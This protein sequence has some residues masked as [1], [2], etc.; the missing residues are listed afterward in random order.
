MWDKTLA[1]CRQAGA[2]ALAHSAYREAV[3][4]F[5][6]ALCALPHLPEQRDLHEQAIDL[7]LT[8]RSALTPFGDA[9]SRQRILA[10]LREAEALAWHCCARPRPSR[11]LSATRVG[12][13]N[14]VM[15]TQYFFYRGMHDQVIASQRAVALA[16]ARRESVLQALA[17][18]FPASPISPGVTTVGRATASGRLWRPSTGPSATLSWA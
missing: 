16:A 10:L 3:A 9:Q 14:H 6:Q 1:Y 5:E 2:K 4:Y 7:R 13:E 11:W 15:L 12:W 8:L 18:F 17:N